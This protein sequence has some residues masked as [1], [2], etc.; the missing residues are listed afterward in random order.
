[1]PRPVEKN[2]GR[3]WTDPEVCIK[4]SS[5]PESSLD[6]EFTHHFPFA[7]Q[8]WPAHYPHPRTWSHFQRVPGD[9]MRTTG[10]YLAETRPAL[11]ALL[12]DAADF[13]SNNHP[14]PDPG[15]GTAS[16]A[17]GLDLHSLHVTD[18]THRAT[19]SLDITAWLRTAET[20]THKLAHGSGPIASSTGA[21]AAAPP[22]VPLCP[23]C[24]TARE[25]SEGRG[26]PISTPRTTS[27]SSGAVDVPRADITRYFDPSTLGFGTDG[28]DYQPLPATQRGDV[29]TTCAPVNPTPPTSPTSTTSTTFPDS[30]TSTRSPGLAQ[31]LVDHNITHRTLDML[32]RLP[33]VDL[34]RRCPSAA[35]VPR[36]LDTLRADNVA[37]TEISVPA[38][39]VDEIKAVLGAHGRWLDDHLLSDVASDEDGPCVGPPVVRWIVQLDADTSE[40]I[41]TRELVEQIAQ[42]RESGCAVVGV[43]CMWQVD[44]LSRGQRAT[45]EHA[46]AR[47]VPHVFRLRS[48]EGASSSKPTWL[49]EYPAARIGHWGRTS[50]AAEEGWVADG[51]AQTWVDGAEEEDLGLPVTRA[52]ANACAAWKG[53]EGMPSVVRAHERA[54]DSAL[55]LDDG[56][57]VRIRECF[58]EWR[59]AHGL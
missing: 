41:A 18:R 32:S 11:E 37:Y 40:D 58:A 10:E 20:L 25:R 57:R 27:T 49:R 7:P 52:L 38:R 29:P 33:K 4:S 44:R 2:D 17:Y 14:H 31:W 13:L 46:R 5:V 8:P 48:E 23:A 19:S 16:I 55:G 9:P 36:V 54:L 28:D 21:A 30:H 59:M 3:P 53:G 22:S 45:L 34:F 51:R 42:F 47:H 15:T 56:G 1:M 50:T 43:E 6:S 26:N 24:A 12:S 35:A 39:S